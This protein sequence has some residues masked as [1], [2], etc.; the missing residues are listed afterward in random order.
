M[1]DDNDDSDMEEVRA[2]GS[3][4]GVAHAA[5]VG[6]PVGDDLAAT[7]KDKKYKEKVKA[8]STR[9]SVG[10]AGLFPTFLF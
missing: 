1:P 7:M 4:S 2:K 5:P 8:A 6:T 3:T 9:F 10:Y